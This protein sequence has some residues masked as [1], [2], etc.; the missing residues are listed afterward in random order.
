MAY[1]VHDV[2]VLNPGGIQDVTPVALTTFREPAGGA[3]AFPGLQG[4]ESLALG[5]I[6]G[7]SA[8]PCTEFSTC[9]GVDGAI[10]QAHAGG[11]A[12]G[13]HFVPLSVQLAAMDPEDV[14]NS[15]ASS[16]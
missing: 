7:Q 8:Q 4:Q 1:Y 14:Q 13:G 12:Q 15:P 5:C 6:E 3:Q 2:Q 16:G 11:G 10:L 9:S